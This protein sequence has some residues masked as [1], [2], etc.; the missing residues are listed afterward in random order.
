MNVRGDESSNARN[1]VQQVPSRTFR[2]AHF[3]APNSNGQ[4]S[5]FP[6][7]MQSF[8][9]T[10]LPPSFTIP[11]V[12]QVHP[13]FMIPTSAI[14]SPVIRI[15]QFNNEA[16]ALA[17]T[18]PNAHF[19]GGYPPPIMNYHPSGRNFHSFITPSQ[20]G[21]PFEA[22]SNQHNR[23]EPCVPQPPAE[24]PN[25]FPDSH[26]NTTPCDQLESTN[27]SSKK[28]PLNLSTFESIAIQRKNELN[29]SSVT[30][31]FVPTANAVTLP[32]A[33]ASHSHLPKQNR[34]SPQLRQTSK[35]ESPPNFKLLSQKARGKQARIG[36]INPLDECSGDQ[37]E[38]QKIKIT[39]IDNQVDILVSNQHISLSHASESTRL[40]L[41]DLKRKKI[42]KISDSFRKN[43]K[44]NRFLSMHVFLKKSLV[45]NT[46]D[47]QKTIVKYMDFSNLR[48]EALSLK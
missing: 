40:Y 4:L 17:N 47:N 43:W 46:K 29:T 7:Q 16:Y 22:L 5:L 9:P 44:N 33:M 6:T 14:A 31:V 26:C 35:P 41:S 2:A 21:L 20:M 25:R 42:K 27:F 39:K 13:F 48:V 30:N 11:F 24:I 34:P 1:A 37:I 15:A 45:V 19:F 38:P 10:P 3:Y 12:V 8:Y 28:R 18:Q 23:Q 36:T 32:P